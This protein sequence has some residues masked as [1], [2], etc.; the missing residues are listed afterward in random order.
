MMTPEIDSQK[1]LQSFL[2]GAKGVIEN[3][4]EL[5][6]INV[7]PVADNDTGNNLASLMQS[8]VDNVEMTTTI[9]TLLNE[10][11]E[12]ALSGA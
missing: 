10:V 3:K 8:I 5:N 1:L 2:T 9:E 6:R 12:A 7:F 11:A 4:E